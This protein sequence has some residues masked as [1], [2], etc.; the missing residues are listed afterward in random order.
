MYSLLQNIY[1]FVRRELL[2]ILNE[3]D[4]AGRASLQCPCTQ[5]FVF[6]DVF[7]DQNGI[8]R[9]YFI[10]LSFLPLF[11]NT[12]LGILDRTGAEYDSSASCLC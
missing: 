7:T 3:C 9:T 10:A 8:K 6:A 12:P 5:A 2:Y 1:E 11:L 4:T